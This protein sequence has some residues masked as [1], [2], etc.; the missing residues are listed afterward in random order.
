MRRNEGL[1]ATYELGWR[2]SCLLENGTQSAFGHVAWMIRNGRVP[3]SGRIEPNLMA[4]CC[5]T[6]ELKSK[7]FESLN[8]LSIPKTGQSPH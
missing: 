3:E 7:G 6:I 1:L 4:A 8:N 5:L 2:H